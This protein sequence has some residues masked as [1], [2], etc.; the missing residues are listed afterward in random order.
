MR[1][2]LVAEAKCAASND[3]F[4]VSSQAKRVLVHLGEPLEE[5]ATVPLPAF[6]RLVTTDP[7]Q[8]M[9]FDPPPGLGPGQRPVWSDDPWTWTAFLR[10]PFRILADHCDVSLDLLRRRCADFMRKEGGR[11]AFGPEAEDTI[12][13]SLRRMTLQFTYRRPLP[14]AAVRG[15]GKMLNE[16]ALANAVDPRV[17][18]T[19]WPEIGGPS[20]S[21]FAIEPEPR[22]DWV[23]QPDLPHREHGGV[24]QEEWLEAAEGSLCSAV[25]PGQFVL[26]EK[27]FSRVTVWRERAECSRLVFPVQVDLTDGIEGLPCLVELD[28]LRPLYREKESKLICRIPSNIF[29]DLGESIITICPFT[30]RS[31]G[32]S[33]SRA[34]PLELLDSDG[35]IVARTVLWIDGTD[36]TDRR[37]TELYGTGQAVILTASG[38]R[39]LEQQYGPLFLSINAT[40][41]IERDGKGEVHRTVVAPEQ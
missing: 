17:F 11:A 31:L 9:D 8:A 26:A 1:D 16:L 32:W 18:P 19:V 38:R 7:D 25:I 5:H 14:M 34:T 23:P 13:A 24:K 39:Q 33:R 2:V 10:F 29:G 22:P 4:V 20:L 12:L 28:D 3:D 6:Y 41:R 40:H 21:G 15:F 27:S 35:S 37:D 36:T 30:A